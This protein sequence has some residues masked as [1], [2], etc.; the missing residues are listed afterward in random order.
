MDLVVVYKARYEIVSQAIGLLRKEG[1]NPVALENPSSIAL[2]ASRG[3]YMTHIA[4][5]REKPGVPSPF[6]RNGRSL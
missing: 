5:P 3:T 1:F 4:V 2:Y 6:W